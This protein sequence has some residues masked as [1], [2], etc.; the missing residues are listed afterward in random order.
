MTLLFRWM[1]FTTL[2]M[3]LH[4]IFTYAVNK[5]A[6][7]RSL[8][9]YCPLTL[10]YR[11]VKVIDEFIRWTYDFVFVFREYVTSALCIPLASQKRWGWTRTNCYLCLGLWAV[12]IINSVYNRSSTGRPDWTCI[13]VGFTSGY[14]RFYTEVSSAVWKHPSTGIPSYTSLLYS[15]GLIT[16]CLG[17]CSWYFIAGMGKR[18][19]VESS[20][21]RSREER[22]YSSEKRAPGFHWRLLQKWYSLPGYT[23]SGILISKQAGLFSV[24]PP[25]MVC[26]C[27]HNFWM[28]IQCCS[29]NAE[30]M[31]SH[32]ILAWLSR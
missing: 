32:D 18:M 3:M 4:S 25:R 5:T 6:P 11:E 27:L 9:T 31:K 15:V 7:Q 23:C 28:K 10:N 22:L 13:V 20:D 30:P 8:V 29:L 26:S 12:K 24:L 16:C 14:V 2:L 1:N 21:R 19:V 17:Q